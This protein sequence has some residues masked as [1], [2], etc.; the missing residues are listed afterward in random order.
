M[1][2]TPTPSSQD[3]T[4]GKAP[5]A[6]VIG[7]G[8]GGLAAAVRLGARGYRVTLLEHLD[9]PGGRA[10][11]FK[12]DGFV[13]DAGPTIVTAPFLFEEL[14]EMCGKRMAD[15]VELREIQPFFRIQ[16]HDGKHFDYTGK[17]DLMRQEVAKFNPDDVAGYDRFMKY[18]KEVFDIGFTELGHAS[19]GRFT[20]MI[21]VAPDLVRLGGYR[22]VYGSVSQYFKSEYLRTVFSFHPLLVGGNPFSTTAVYNLI[23]Y[24]EH[25][26]GVHFA[27]GGTGKL[28][29]GL[30]DLIRGQGNEVR[31]QATVDEITVDQGKVSGVRLASGET[32]AADVVV[33]NADSAATYR[34]LL[35]ARYRKRW[36]DKRLDRSRYSMSLM[37]WYFGTDKRY[38]DVEHHTIL[39]GPRYR[40][41]VDEI[42]QAK[43]LPDDFSLYLHRPTATDPSLAPEGCDA[44]YVLSPVPHLDADIDWETAAEPYRAKIEQAL[45]ET[46]LPDLGRHVVS[47]HMITPPYFQ[48]TLLSEKGAAF[49]LAP[50]LLQSA[51]FR[52]HNKSEEVDNLFLVG[53]GTHPGAGLPGV[54]SSARVL[55]EV[56]PDANT[57]A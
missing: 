53:A 11:V 47:S 37:V 16:F 15:H 40:A 10:Y 4:G 5:H 27:M 8:F 26:W 49:G 45:S 18:S 1:L 39:L 31:F 32:I 23:G 12:Q 51:W 56:V 34:R 21:K 46:L 24:L 28:A 35:P 36:T 13:F 17:T 57:F 42:F 20:D 9:A 14:W 50:S 30:V 55:D 41:L 22:S 33:S 54:V 38:E 7:A 48:D 2:Q 3:L 19:F 6:V 52:P 43:D 29:E 25:E 44:F